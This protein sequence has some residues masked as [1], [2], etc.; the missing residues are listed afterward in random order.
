[1]QTMYKDEAITIAPNQDRYLLSDFQHALGDLSDGFWFERCAALYWHVNVRDR[2]FFSPHHVTLPNEMSGA[3]PPRNLVRVTCID[4]QPDGLRS[5][6]HLSNH[7]SKV[8]RLPWRRVRCAATEKRRSRSRTRTRRKAPKR[9]HRSPGCTARSN[10]APRTRASTARSTSRRSPRP[11]SAP[12][13]GRMPSSCV[14]VD[15]STITSWIIAPA[16]KRGPNKRRIIHGLL[17]AL[18]QQ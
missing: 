11:P 12:K 4:V 18:P 14:R 1:M 16:L 13:L 10:P 6:I 5:A 3:A 17:K 2:E 9:P 7:P 15:A 8:W